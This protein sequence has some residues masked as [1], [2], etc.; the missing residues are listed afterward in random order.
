[1]CNIYAYAKHYHFHETI[2]MQKF[3][4]LKVCDTSLPQQ[5][6]LN[7]ANLHIVTYQHDKTYAQVDHDPGGINCVFKQ[8]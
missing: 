5:I 1:M 4:L 2:R 7:D 8:T 6:Q 3:Q